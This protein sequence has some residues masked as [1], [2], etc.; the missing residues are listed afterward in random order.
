MLTKP[1]I[2][3]DNT[4][5]IP[6]ELDGGRKGIHLAYSR[7]WARDSFARPH[8]AAQ[9]EERIPRKRPPTSQ[10]LTVAEVMAPVV[11]LLRRIKIL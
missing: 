4:V 9:A 7:D 5:R 1:G 6:Q 11:G 10:R 2:V 8:A 3:D